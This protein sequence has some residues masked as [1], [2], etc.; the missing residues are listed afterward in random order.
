MFLLGSAVHRPSQSLDS[1]PELSNSRCLTSRETILLTQE[2]SGLAAGRP[3]TGDGRKEPCV[4]FVD[5]NDR[6]FLPRHKGG[7]LL[8]ATQPYP[9]CE[10][11]CWQYSSYRSALSK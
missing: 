10:I 2:A 4:V 1:I 7:T 6:N 11:L 8:D 9:A 5:D 3:T